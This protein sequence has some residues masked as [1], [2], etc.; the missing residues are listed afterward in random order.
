MIIM[1]TLSYNDKHNLTM[2][3]H[4]PYYDHNDDNNDDNY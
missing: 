3:N 1:I 4:E 2:H